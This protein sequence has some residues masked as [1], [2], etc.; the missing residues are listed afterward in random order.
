MKIQPESLLANNYILLDTLDHKDIIPFIKKYI[1]QKTISAIFYYA[2]CGISLGVIG[3]YA[4]LLYFSSGFKG[5]DIFF[6]IS[7]GFLLPF[8][9]IPLH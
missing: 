7:L 1:K 9:L 3:A 5:E 2:F 6:H 8:L 4:T